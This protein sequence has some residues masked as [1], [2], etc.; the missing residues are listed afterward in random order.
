MAVNSIKKWGQFVIYPIKISV[1]FYF[2]YIRSE[3]LADLWEPS[4]SLSVG[5]REPAALY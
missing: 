5:L 2:W 4:N 1:I 3:A